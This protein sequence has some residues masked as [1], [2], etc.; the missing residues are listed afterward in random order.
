MYRLGKGKINAYSGGS[1]AGRATR[2]S[3]LYA[4][5]A[6]ETNMRLRRFKNQECVDA[7]RVAAPA[8][9]GGVIAGNSGVSYGDALLIFASRRKGADSGVIGHVERQRSLLRR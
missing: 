6:C 5:M 4:L 2:R 9:G 8:R 1:Q 3:R 7:S